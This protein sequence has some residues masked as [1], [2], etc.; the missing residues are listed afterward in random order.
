MDRLIDSSKAF[1]PM[2]IRKLSA[3]S[4]A[5]DIPSFGRPDATE[6]GVFIH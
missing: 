3:A 5:E 4:A 2:A 1:G 6:D